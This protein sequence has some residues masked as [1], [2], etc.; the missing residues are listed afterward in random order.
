MN[1]ILIDGLG[2]FAL[3]INLYSMSTKGEYKL[4]LYAL[5][6]NALY[7]FYGVFLQATPIIL[8]CTIAVFLHA[9]HLKNISSKKSIHDICKAS[10]RK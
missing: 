4:R 5:C 8:G 1:T 3:A 2:Y 6:A 9:Y 10:N 7:I